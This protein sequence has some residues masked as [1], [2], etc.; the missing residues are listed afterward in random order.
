MSLRVL[1]ADES[2]SIRKVFQ[3]G[4]QDFGAEVKSVHN[5]LDVI[6]VAESFRPHIIFADILLQKKN[7]YEVSEEL[8]EHSELQSTPLVLM[9]SSFMELDHKRFKSCGAQGELEKPFE[10]E[11]MRSLIRDLVE[12]TQGQ[13][14]ADFLSFPKSIKQEFI[15]EFNQSMAKPQGFNDGQTVSVITQ[16][17]TQNKT[18]TAPQPPP[19]SEKPVEF[20]LETVVINNRP[21]ETFVDEIEAGSVFNLQMDDPDFESES[22][23]KAAPKEE[24]MD[25][26]IDDSWTARSLNDQ[27]LKASEEKKD[28]EFEGFETVGIDDMKKL[29]LDDFLYKPS[30]GFTPPPQP[31]IENTKT[32]EASNDIIHM[33][34][35][36]PTQITTH[37]NQQVPSS[38]SLS[39]EETESIIR[40]EVRSLFQKSLS[41]Q[42]PSMLEKI[43]REELK[44]V[45][46]EELALKLNSNNLNAE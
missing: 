38:A 9:W 37:P 6:Q 35:S 30:E 13:K 40:S 27:S 4:L 45:L 17:Q 22:P 46:E 29:K 12:Y 32:G 23:K 42:L 1:L 18:E 24:K 41:Q 11:S 3:L 26:S 33:S 28:D 20:N 31:K 19:K 34:P 21:D 14:I 8:R 10:V 2:A 39:L 25:F 5:G 16:N 7:G 43:I 36:T 15:D 44:R